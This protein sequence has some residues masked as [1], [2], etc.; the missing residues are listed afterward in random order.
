MDSLSRVIETHRR[1]RETSSFE[2]GLFGGN[3]PF[4]TSNDIAA[5]FDADTYFP[6]R[7]YQ[8]AV[9]F[10][11]HVC[12]D[13]IGDM[14]GEEV[15]CATHIDN[16]PR[17]RSWVR[18]PERQSRAF[19]LQTSQDKFYPDFVVALDDDRVAAIEYKGADR[20]DSMD[21][22]EK[23]LIGKKWASVSGGLCIFE[24]V[25]D[26]DYALIDATLRAKT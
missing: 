1:D 24:M 6:A 26:K 11:K 18:N 13:R 9:R 7:F 3:L 25:K 19:W 16:H 22:Q 2:A 4:K 21:T 23:E 5:V 14:N 20:A 15:Q 12:P 8:G 17:V 10:K